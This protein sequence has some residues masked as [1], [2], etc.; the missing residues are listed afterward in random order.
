VAQGESSL[1]GQGT[2]LEQLTFE[3]PNL[4]SG[5]ITAEVRYVLGGGG[6]GSGFDF[7]G[8]GIQFLA[9]P[10][11]AKKVLGDFVDRSSNLPSA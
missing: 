8:L 5:P 10:A 6:D 3:H 2:I 9:V 7:L 11:E 4:T 1:F